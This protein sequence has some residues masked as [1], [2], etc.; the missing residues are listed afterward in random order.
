M[1]R[2]WIRL[3]KDMLLYGPVGP[4]HVGLC[5]L[6]GSKSS[7]QPL[8]TIVI[9]QVESTRLSLPCQCTGGTYFVL[10]REGMASYCDKYLLASRRLT[11]NY[12]KGSALR[13]I[14]ARCVSGGWID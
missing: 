6:I 10:V 12:Y 4:P 11:P 14:P 13:L 8:L 1:K 7:C 2:R 3:E 5:L 9:V